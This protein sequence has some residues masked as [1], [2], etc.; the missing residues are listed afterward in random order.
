MPK[1]RALSET[2]DDAAVPRERVAA[3]AYNAFVGPRWRKG[4]KIHNAVA[5][6]RTAPLVAVK[7]K[8]RVDFRDRDRGRAFPRI[9]S[10]GG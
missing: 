8:T 3:R 7:R 6:T 2:S 1:I 4:A 5:A 10:R 9:R